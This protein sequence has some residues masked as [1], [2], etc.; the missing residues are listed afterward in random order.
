LHLGANRGWAEGDSYLSV[1]SYIGTNRGDKISGDGG[2]DRFFGGNG[3][4]FLRGRGGKDVL[5]GG[6]GNDKIYGGS[7]AD[8][9]FGDDGHDTLLGGSSDDSLRGGGGNDTLRGGIGADRFVHSG[10]SADGHD[11]IIDYSAAERDLLVFDRSGASAD[12]FRVD[13]RHTGGENLDEAYITYLPTGQLLW[14]LQDAE[15]QNHIFVQSG[16]RDFDLL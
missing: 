5:T 4:D 16:S 9:L 1:E 13:F 11:W 12:Q 3:A 14:I 10:T 6:K 7:R 8:T 15:D 2:A